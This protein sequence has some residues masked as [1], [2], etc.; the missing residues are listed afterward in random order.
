M[1]LLTFFSTFPTAL[2]AWFGGR[3]LASRL[4]E[5]G[6]IILGFVV[7]GIFTLAIPFTSS[8]WLLM[9]T[10]ALAGFGTGFTS[11]VLMSLSIKHMDTGKRATAMGF[12]QAIYGLGM[13]GGPL[14][15]VLA[16][17]WLSLIG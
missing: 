14:M 2:A 16:G 7:S 11:P 15:M 4:G 3:H 12:Y 8:L 6:T 1:G 13:F 5:N 10:Q 17:D 9:L